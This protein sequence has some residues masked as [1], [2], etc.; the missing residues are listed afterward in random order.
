MANQRDCDRYEEDFPE[1]R[2]SLL[3][4]LALG[5]TTERK[6]EQARK[7][8]KDGKGKYA[9]KVCAKMADAYCVSESHIRTARKLATTYTDEEVQEY[10]F[11]ARLARV[12]PKKHHLVLLAGVPDQDERRTWQ[13]LLLENQWSIKKL[14][15]NLQEAKG[16][17]HKGYRAADVPKTNEEARREIEWLLQRFVTYSTGWE[18]ACSDPSY[19]DAVGCF[20]ELGPEVF[21]H[22][23]VV[24]QG[25][26]NMLTAMSS[27][28]ESIAA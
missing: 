24:K 8:I 3:Q 6:M 4:I 9:P 10:I 21:D 1:K 26:G 19:A 25:L 17:K 2:D 15:L 22:A 7:S 16:R 13:T 23:L 27:G 5:R 28:S 14:K 12:L 11:Q 18:R 20:V